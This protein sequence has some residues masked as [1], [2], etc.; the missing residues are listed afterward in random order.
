MFPVEVVVVVAAAV[1]VVDAAVVDAAVVDAVVVD[2]VAAVM[3]VDVVI[4]P[5]RPVAV[6]QRLDVALVVRALVGAEHHLPHHYYYQRCAVEPAWF[7][8]LSNAKHHRCRCSCE[9]VVVA[10]ADVAAAASGDGFVVV[11]AV[12][13]AAAACFAVAKEEP[14]HGSVAVVDA[15]VPKTV[16]EWLQP[17][18]LADA[19]HPK[20]GTRVPR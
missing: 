17:L 1:A 3:L 11:A 2:V 16:D 8:I 7:A 13:V 9:L 4:L 12:V 10:G 19:E 6:P 15:A 18:A 14:C 20:N 5:W